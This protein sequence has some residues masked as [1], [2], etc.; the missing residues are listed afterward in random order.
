MLKLDKPYSFSRQEWQHVSSVLLPYVQSNGGKKGWEKGDNESKD[1]RNR[2]SE[3]TLFHQHNKCAYCEGFITEGAQLDHFVPKQLHPEFC[4]EPKNLLTSCAVCNMYI[5]NGGDTITPPIK[6]RY[7]QNHFTIV[8]PYFNDPDV[9][10]KYT[11]EDRVVVDR[12]GSTA[13][14]KATIDFFHMNDYPAYCR[15]AQWFRDLKKYPIDYIRLAKDCSA[16][17]R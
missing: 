15:R 5:K 3:Y 8:H 13:L 12:N 14:G 4:Y 1:I 9:H 17:K 16:Y 7:E 11:N 10:I 6:R 2:I